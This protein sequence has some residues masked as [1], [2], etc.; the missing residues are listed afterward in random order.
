M[1]NTV[2]IES[3]VYNLNKINMITS[4][5]KHMLAGLVFLGLSAPMHA[6]K[7]TS[8]KP[9][10]V[11]GSGRLVKEQ[12]AVKY[13]NALQIEYVSGKVKVEIGGTVSAL[14]AQLDDNLQP[15]LHLEE[16][17]ST[18]KL[19]FRDGQGAPVW[20]IDASVEITI[21][22]PELKGV[23]YNTN[24]I[25]TVSGIGGYSFSLINKANGKVKLQG[26]VRSLEVVSMA[27]GFIEAGELLARTANV[28]THA[29][30]TVQVNA[31]ELNELKSGHGSI[32]N[33]FRKPLSRNI[34]Y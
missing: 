27:N 29:N 20:T 25:L 30:A 16:E 18:L 32:V 5:F 34:A 10:E 14:E 2:L 3:I 7:E 8:E 26:K 23:V 21:K 9:V 15:L 11:H 13:F 17:D 24:G 4:S 33:V 19:S 1:K 22:T 6:Q 12:K 28:V 31:K